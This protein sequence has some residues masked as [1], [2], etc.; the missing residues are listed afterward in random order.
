[1]RN[2]ITEEMDAA[3]GLLVPDHRDEGLNSRLASDVSR[4]QEIEQ[5]SDAL[6][7]KRTRKELGKLRANRKQAL[8]TAQASGNT[9]KAN[10]IAQEVSVIE[11]LEAETMPYAIETLRSKEGADP[12]QTL[13]PVLSNRKTEVTRLMQNLN[14]NL[15]MGLTKTDTENLLAALLTASE[16]QL[17]A[18]QDNPAVPVAVKTVIVRL[19]ADMQRGETSTIER[20]WD[21][22][23]GKPA[24]TNSLSV[25]LGGQGAPTNPANPVNASP[26]AQPTIVPTTPVSREAYLVIRETLLQ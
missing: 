25:G 20:L 22:I 11:E 13:A 9:D 19:L 12:V 1:M 10:Q 3:L 26:T 17:R 7:R 8:A 6:T 23:F 18:I 24:N 21:R 14:I 2:K 15:D 4:K 16:S 5:F